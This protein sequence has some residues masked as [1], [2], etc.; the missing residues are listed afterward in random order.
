[1]TNV[2]SCM[3]NDKCNM[4]NVM[5]QMQCDK[6]NMTYSLKTSIF[7]KFSTYPPPVCFLVS[8]LPTTHPTS[9]LPYGH[10]LRPRLEVTQICGPQ[11]NNLGRVV[12]TFPGYL[13]KHH[14]NLLFKP[15]C[16]GFRF[17]RREE[18]GA[19]RI[20]PLEINDGMTCCYRQIVH[21]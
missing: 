15:A 6:C 16:E 1:M 18:M 14:K 4:T 20:P 7:L 9:L 2:I 19:S 21:W 11:S 12:V 13:I 17:W 10:R 5:W 3:Q 8:A